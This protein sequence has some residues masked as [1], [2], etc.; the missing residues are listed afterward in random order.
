MKSWMFHCF[1][2]SLRC[3]VVN[4]NLEL[5]FDFWFLGFI[6]T[7]Q[8]SPF[9]LLMPVSCWLIYST[10]FTSVSFSKSCSSCACT[11]S[12]CFHTGNYGD[13]SIH[14]KF[15]VSHCLCTEGNVTFRIC[16]LIFSDS[17]WV[18]WKLP[19]P[20]LVCFQTR[21]EHI[22]S[23]SQLLIT[24]V[25]LAFVI[26]LVNHSHL[27]GIQAGTFVWRRGPEYFSPLCGSNYL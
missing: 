23:S 9:I 3:Q 12:T 27:L 25:P 15:N 24:C 21:T 2:G 1:H 11:L 14:L 18:W 7:V 22:V 5:Y 20:L 10:A 6:P 13:W 17:G 8:M 26:V 19:L 16:W 4:Q